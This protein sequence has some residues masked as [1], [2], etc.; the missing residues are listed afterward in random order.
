MKLTSVLA[1]FLLAFS[2]AA[3]SSDWGAE[4]N[5]NPS[6]ADDNRFTQN[7]DLTGSQNTTPQDLPDWTQDLILYQMRIDTFGE[8]ATINSAREKLHTLAHL[9][10]TGVVLTPIA[11]SFKGSSWDN[12][13]YSGY[14]SHVEPDQIDPV[15][16]TD[17]DFTAFVDELH[18]M[19]IKVF[20]DF[21]FHGVFDPDVF[22]TKMNW[23]DA[24]NDSYPENRSSLLDTHPEFF[25]WTTSPNQTGVGPATIDHPVYTDWNT[26]ELIWKLPNGQDNNA[27]K[28]WFKNVL[29]NDWIDK[30]DLD[31]LRLDLE[32]YEVANEVGYDYWEDI[33]IEAKTVTGRDIILIPE[34]GNAGRNDAFA[35][36][37]EDFGVSNPRF[38]LPGNVKDFMVSEH[39]TNYPENNPDHN[40]TV[41][42]VNI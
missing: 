17:A 37:Q 26:A 40:L 28:A 6:F 7:L 24:Y 38:G 42:P 39:L 10:I 8:L 21:E 36:A 4:T 35:F 1:F 22:R 16:G 33:K 29:V 2:P 41:D 9:G 19:G 12:P 25:T 20:L 18:A 13:E 23:I 5:L 14:Y 32:P 27:L 30:F 15:L 34:D 11:K 3:Y 31:G